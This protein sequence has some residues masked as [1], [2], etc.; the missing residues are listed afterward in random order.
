[1][2]LILG[3]INLRIE[4]AVAPILDTMAAVLVFHPPEE[5]ELLRLAGAN[6]RK[7]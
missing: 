4:V 5:G 6:I 7:R 1:M 2:M 3:G